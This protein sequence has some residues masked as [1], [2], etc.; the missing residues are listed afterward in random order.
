MV[1]M[2]PFQNIYFSL[3]AGR[4]MEKIKSDYDLD[5]W[6]ISYRQVLEYI[7]ANDKN[8]RI[9]LY[10]DNYPAKANV[11]ILD[12]KDRKRLVFVDRIKD[13]T[14]FLGNYRWHKKDYTHGRE[15][16]SVKLNGTKIVAVHKIG[17]VVMQ[18]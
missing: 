6:G 16:F 5:Y 15:Y 10:A 13:A 18:Q 12:E 17:E 4:S 9:M 2:H 14:Y 8:E 11:N 1:T 3:L 7:V